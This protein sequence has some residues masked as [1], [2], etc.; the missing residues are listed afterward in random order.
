MARRN[1]TNDSKAPRDGWMMASKLRTGRVS[2]PATAHAN[3]YGGILE[4]DSILDAVGLGDATLGGLGLLRWPGGHQCPGNNV[5]RRRRGGLSG[6]RFN[7]NVHI[8]HGT[9][10]ATTPM[11]PF[12]TGIHAPA[13]RVFVSA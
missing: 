5:E 13:C 4:N 10:Q 3:Y 1:K 2:Q 9:V 7:Q 12:H 11:L 6:E 8:V